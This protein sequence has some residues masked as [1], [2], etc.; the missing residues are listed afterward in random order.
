[1]PCELVNIGEFVC[2]ETFVL[3]LVAFLPN[4]MSVNPEKRDQ[5]NRPGTSLLSGPMCGY[6]PSSGHSKLAL[7]KCDCSVL[8]C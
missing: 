8:M 6:E 4:C 5:F 2:G 3:N 7:L 1:M